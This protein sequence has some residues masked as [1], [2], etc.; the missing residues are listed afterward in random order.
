MS[1]K[2]WTRRDLLK[3]GLGTAAS[4]A[5]FEGVGH[6]LPVAGG[7]KF[8]IAPP[9][10]SDWSVAD[11]FQLSRA[12]GQRNSQLQLATLLRLQQ[13]CAQESQNDWT[14]ITVKVFD[15]VHPPLVFAL[16]QLDANGQVPQLDDKDPRFKDMQ[17]ATRNYLVQNKIKVL[18]TNS[19]FKALRLNEW[20]GSRLLNGTIDGSAT[21][22]AT[23]C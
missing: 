1:N 2:I 13:A 17:D 7:R 19:R 20:F 9:P 14:I 3:L 10:L 18:S 8:P 15:Q 11:A 21:A 5:L 12:L 22:S 4:M 23:T 16:G 6:L